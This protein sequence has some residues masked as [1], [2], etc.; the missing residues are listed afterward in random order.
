MWSRF[1]LFICFLLGLGNRQQV[2]K[3]KLM[4]QVADSSRKPQRIY[5]LLF[6]ILAAVY[7]SGCQASLTP[8]IPTPTP[9][10]QRFSL[11]TFTKNSVT[12]LIEW[13]VDPSGQINLVGTYTPTESDL[14]LYGKDLPRRGIDG[15][16]RP[17]R[18]DI[19]SD[20]AVSTG[21]LQENLTPTMHLFKG[22]VQPFPLYP[23]GPVTL[24]QPIQL[25]DL[26][27]GSSELELSVTYMA[28]SSDGLCKPPVTDNHF[29]VT[30]PA[31]GWQN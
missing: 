31:E 29:T 1:A 6:C 13:V 11:H 5:V 10:V 23:D 16:G 14:H 3:F 8:A 26:P 18:L 2:L 28:C 24:T 20:T 25:S 19:V 15:V 30:I 17:T 7:M 22:F 4:H 12:V 21:P 9:G 27:S